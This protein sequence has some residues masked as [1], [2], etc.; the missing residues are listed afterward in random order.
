MARPRMSCHRINLL[1]FLTLNCY[2]SLVTC[3][4]LVT[5]C[6]PDRNQ[7]K[8]VWGS[9]VQ[10]VFIYL[11]VLV[12]NSCAEREEPSCLFYC[13]SCFVILYMPTVLRL[14][15][16]VRFPG[17][18]SVPCVEDWQ[19]WKKFRIEKWY[20]I[21]ATLCKLSNKYLT[22]SYTIGKYLIRYSFT[23]NKLWRDNLP[24]FSI[25]MAHSNFQTWK[26]VLYWCK[27]LY[28]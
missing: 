4:T 21:R 19:P 7:G 16:L 26:I 1:M 15:Y 20:R 14:F 24:R 22:H 17:R 3:H 8:R 2:L 12:C 11:V 6:Q 5:E 13:T 10:A 23:V 27:K 28:S 9:I 25:S 18:E